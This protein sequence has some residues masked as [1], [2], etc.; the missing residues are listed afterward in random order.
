MS[1]LTLETLLDEKAIQR[2]LTRYGYVND[3]GDYEALVALFTADGALVRP[4]APDEPIVGREA[5]LATM[6]A[7]PPR[8]ARHLVCNVEIDV[9]DA[10][11]ARARS[12]MVLIS[13]TEAGKEVSVGGFDD[14][15]VKQDGIWLF[16]SRTGSTSI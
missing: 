10:T 4:T 5:I 6:R 3:A 11:Q 12:T 14:E 1:A 13:A 9:I 16:A 15:I 8:K 2:L 7:R